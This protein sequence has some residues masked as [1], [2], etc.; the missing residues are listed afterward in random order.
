MTSSENFFQSVNCWLSNTNLIPRGTLGLCCAHIAQLMT[1]TTHLHMAVYLAI[2]LLK[3]LGILQRVTKSQK[4][5]HISNKKK[6][7]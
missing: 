5:H 6:Q 4:V 1:H 2:M 7:K 3:L